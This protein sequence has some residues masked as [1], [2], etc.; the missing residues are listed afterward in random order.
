MKLLAK[1]AEERHQTAAAF[2]E[3]LDRWLL[4][5]NAS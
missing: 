2:F 1:A 3:A 4:D 5:Y